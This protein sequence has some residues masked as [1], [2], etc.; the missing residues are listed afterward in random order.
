MVKR[1]NILISLGV[2]II[3]SSFCLVS[4]SIT[5]SKPRDDFY[6]KL[7]VFAQALVVIEDK[8]VSLKPPEELIEGALDGVLNS[9]DSYSQYLT[10]QAYKDLLV[11]TQGKF[12]GL[13]IEIMIVDGALT[14]VSPLEDSPA[15]K[16]GIKPADIIIKIN[17]EPTKGMN[18]NQAVDKLRGK[19]K[20]KVVLTIL[21]DKD[22]IEIPLVKDIVKIQDI[23]HALLLDNNIGYIKIAEF[24]DKTAQDLDKALIRLKKEGMRGLIIDLRNNPGGLLDSA[25]D[26]VSRFLEEGKLIVTMRSRD[27]APEVFKASAD[28]IK[29]LKTPMAVIINKG[30]ASGSEIF[31]AALR[32]NDRAR[33]LGETTFGKGSVQTIFPLSD[34]SALRLTTATYYTPLNDNI[35]ERGVTPDIIMKDDHNQ[36]DDSSTQNK[37][38]DYKKDPIIVRAWD[39]V[40]AQSV[41]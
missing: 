12:A 25:I 13:G 31:A 4:F 18:L 26:I 37:Q 23:K 22:L 32:Q 5:K 34:G 33:L 41:K 21:R 15:F 40:Q 14:V 28:T 16:A 9:L 30:S 8:Y 36:D 10:P 24:R 27:Q 11:E 17:G 29:I 3:I 7:D 6:R 39:L 2:F 38:F 20:E 1:R 19:P 35:N